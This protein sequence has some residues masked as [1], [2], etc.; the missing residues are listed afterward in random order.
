EVFDV[1][2]NAWTPLEK[3]PAAVPDR[4]HIAMAAIGGKI[5]VAGG[6]YNGGTVSSPRTDALDVY[7]PIAKTWTPKKAMRRPRGGVAGV[8][9]YGCFF[10]FGGEGTNTGERNDVFPDH[11]VYDPRTDTWTALKPLPIPFHGVTG[12][13]FVDGLIHMPGGGTSSGGNSGS[14]MHQT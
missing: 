5:Y 3:L 9:A 13:A 8:A 6:R 14:V 2:D 4:N 7:D 11:D 1:G 12:S 10:V